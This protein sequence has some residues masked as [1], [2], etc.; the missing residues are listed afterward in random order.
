MPHSKP[1]A[2]RTRKLLRELNH[3]ASRQETFWSNRKNLGE[4][5]HAAKQFHPEA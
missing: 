2:A 5:R 3:P 4:F 1:A